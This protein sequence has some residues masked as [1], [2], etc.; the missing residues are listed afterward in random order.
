GQSIFP[1][2][3]RTLDEA[4]QYV[5]KDVTPDELQSLDCRMQELVQHQFQTLAQ[6]CLGSANLLDNLESAMQTEVERFLN[7]RLGNLNIA[8]MYLTHQGE[9]DQA[10]ADLAQAFTQA[11]PGLAGQRLSSDKEIRFPAV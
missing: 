8:E 4:V 11:A 1:A 5:L 6:V 2:G 7:D 9:N 3:C 10:Q